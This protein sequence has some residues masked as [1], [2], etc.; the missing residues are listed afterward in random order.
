MGI[1]TKLYPLL[2]LCVEAL[3]PQ[4]DGIWRWGLWEVL[5]FRWGYEV[6][7]PHEGISAFIRRDTRQLASSLCF[8]RTQ[9][10][11]HCLP[12]R[13]RDLSRNW[14]T[15]HH[16]LKLTPPRTVRKWEASVVEATQS[17]V[18]RYGSPSRLIQCGSY[19][20]SFHLRQGWD[21]NSGLH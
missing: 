19:R 3:T 9:W 20:L 6:G 4:C 2:N 21:Q 7:A 12:P 5:R 1:W 17:M 13:K 18:F 11:S 15:W 16:D 8:V 14:P 10:E